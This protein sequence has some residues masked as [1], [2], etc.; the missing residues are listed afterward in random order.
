M[1]DCQR[2]LVVLELIEVLVLWTSLP[3]KMLR[4]VFNVVLFRFS[5]RD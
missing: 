2:N 5:Y 1:F 4:F 3:N